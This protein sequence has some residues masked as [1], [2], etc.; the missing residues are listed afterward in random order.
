MAKNSLIAWTD[1]TFNPWWGCT[2]VSPACDHCYAEMVSTRWHRGQWGKDTARWFPSDAYWHE[3]LTWNARAQQTGIRARVFCASMADV[4]EVH[5]A[6]PPH[7]A[8]LW[9]LIAETPMLDWLLLTKRPAG[10]RTLI[11][12]T[13]LALP[14]VWPGVTVES[15]DY[16][17]RLDQ[18][19][20]MAAAG[21]RW[22]SY[23]P[24]LERVD[25]SPW[26]PAV[27]WVIA[28]G[29]SGSRARPF[30]LAWARSV[31][32]Q[33]RR[34]GVA[35]FVKQ[36]GSRPVVNGT[37][38]S[39]PTHHDP[40]LWPADLRVREYPEEATSITPSRGPQPL[41]LARVGPPHA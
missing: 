35:P 16:T 20:E 29:E 12:P 19:A 31:I 9:R 30:D 5:D 11:P 37:R 40:K 17:W 33:C 6:L 10:Y 26:L 22:V 7:R 24:A 41:A 3:P 15:E 2:K 36:L 28:G 1:H 13:L 27:S 38:L 8:R 25:F 4:F 21:P 23:E 39:L 14:R 34:A 32:A 18:L